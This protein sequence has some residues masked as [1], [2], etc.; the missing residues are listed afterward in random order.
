MTNLA[1]DE[2][3]F[4]KPSDD[5]SRPARPPRKC[6][7]PRAAR[8]RVV[9]GHDSGELSPMYERCARCGHQFDPVRSR[10]GR[11]NRKRGNSAELDVARAI[12][13][14]KVGPL[15]GPV[16]VIREGWLKL[17]VKKL[18]VWPSLNT[19]VSWM[20]A[21]PPSRE[22]RGV[23]LIEAAGMGRRGRRLLVLDL[24]EFSEHHGDPTKETT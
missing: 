2:L 7:H 14:R 21:I 20:D 11:N 12:G 18:S 15:G 5:P 9:M 17:Q 6:P 4:S 22:M 13:G 8:Q 16:D 19:V 1:F 10:A 3:P 23:A 24:D